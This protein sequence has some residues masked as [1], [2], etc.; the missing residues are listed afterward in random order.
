MVPNRSSGAVLSPE[1]E[2]GAMGRAATEA[3]LRIPTCACRPMRINHVRA[4]AT[5]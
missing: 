2:T 1:P 3:Q 5:K 4:A